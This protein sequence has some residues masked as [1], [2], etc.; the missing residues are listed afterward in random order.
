MIAKDNR[1]FY[2]PIFF[3]K[4]GNVKSAFERH[5]SKIDGTQHKTGNVLFDQRRSLI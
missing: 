1:D 2:S 4:V 5:F 3:S